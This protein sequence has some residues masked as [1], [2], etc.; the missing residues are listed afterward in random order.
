[1]SQDP[2]II[3][4]ALP[5]ELLV[6]VFSLLPHDRLSQSTLHACTLVSHLWCTSSIEQLYKDPWL[7]STNFKAFIRT[8]CPSINP[9]IR[10]NGLS[11]F[12]RRLDM[13]C[14]VHDGSKSL[15]ARLLGRV[16][17]RLEEFVAPQVSFGY[18]YPRHTLRIEAHW[19]VAY[20]LLP[21]YRNVT[22]FGIWI[23]L[24]YLGL[25]TSRY[26]SNQSATSPNSNPF[27]YPTLPTGSGVVHAL[28][29]LRGCQSCV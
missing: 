26:F 11:N 16:K 24:W 19:W 6:R 5:A 12:I 1:M 15:T 4:C 25:L 13:S 28:N 9:H 2:Q 8:V 17:E 3:P 18:T 23:Y 7:T 20:F 27:I 22:I 21:A 29:G 10:A 14:L